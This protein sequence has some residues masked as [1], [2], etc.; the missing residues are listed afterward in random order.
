MARG[1]QHRKR[2]PPANA[3]VTAPAP[4]KD[5]VQHARWEDQLFFSRLRV[6]AKW[7]FA[8]LAVIFGL[9]FV[10]FGVGSGSSGIADIMQNFFSSSSGGGSSLSSLQKKAREHPKDAIAWRNLTTKLEQDQKIDRAVVALAHYVKLRPK[11]ESAFEELGAMYARRA[12][13]YD[14]AWAQALSSL[15]VVSPSSVFQPL[16][17]SPLAKA[18]ASKDPISA[19]A[20][21]RLNATVSSAQRNVGVYANQA[22]RA[23]QRLAQLAPQNATYQFQLGDMA[24]SLSQKAVAIKAYKAFLKLAPNDSLAPRARQQLKALSALPAKK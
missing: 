17:G 20:V 24:Q 5:R 15:Q 3:A 13:D 1:T 6:H 8:V 4:K 23:Y 10:L 18:F 21:A 7:M 19:V 12:Q 9:T 22:M 2:R 11:D 16:S 14:Q